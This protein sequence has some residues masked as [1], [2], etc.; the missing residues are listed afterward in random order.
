LL[1]TMGCGE[2]CPLVPGLERQD[3]SLEDPVRQPRER[4][5][6]IRDEVRRRVDELLRIN[7]WQR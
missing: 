5:R 7:A 3:W 1:V 2:A 4:V 6:K